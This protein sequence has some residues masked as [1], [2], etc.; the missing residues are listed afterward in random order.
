MTLSTVLGYNIPIM[1]K[2]NLLYQQVGD[3]IKE[4]REGYG[5]KGLS[6]EALAAAVKT[7]PNT[8]SRWE[9]AVYKPKVGDLEK[10]AVFFSV[11]ISVFFPSLPE[12]KPELK[13]LMSATADLHKND[14]KE[15]TDFALFRKARS[16][17]KEVRK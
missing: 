9:K 10:L 8:V 4:L 6:Q 1:G 15:V 7:K 12:E 2:T 16:K 5:G 13:A 17:L 11:P 14:L 3:K